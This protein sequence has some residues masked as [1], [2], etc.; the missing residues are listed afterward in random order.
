M[1]TNTTAKMEGNWAKLSI[2]YLCS[3]INGHKICKIEAKVIMHK[4]C[5]HRK[6]DGMYINYIREIM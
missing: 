6:V 1:N 5:N 2:I 4:F 3:K